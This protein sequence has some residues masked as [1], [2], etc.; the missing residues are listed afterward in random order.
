MHDPRA[1][2]S[3]CRSL[4]RSSVPFDDEAGACA[5][6][7]PGVDGVV[8]VWRSQ[9]ATFI[10]QMW[11]QLPEPAAF[12]AELKQ[13]AGFAPDFWDHDVELW[14]YTATTAIDPAA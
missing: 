10:P 8:F 1:S 7:R 13:K 5:A 4:R 3:R 6:L 14:R 9:R 11:A 2:P 12:L